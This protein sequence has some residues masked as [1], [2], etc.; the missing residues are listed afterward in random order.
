ME[1]RRELGDTQP[2]GWL[3]ALTLALLLGLASAAV[4][5]PTA[6]RGEWPRTDFSRHTVPFDEIESGGPPK[7]GIPAVDRPRFVSQKDAA[8]WLDA[9]EPVIVFEHRGEARAYPLQILMFHEIVNDTVGG[10]PV[11]VTFCPLCNA[12]IVF[13]RR[14]DGALLDFGT[15]GK[16]RKS[17]L[18]MY[19]R[20]TESWWQQFTGKGIVG[21]YADATLHQMPSTIAAFADFREAYPLGRVL[22][23]ETGYFRPYGKNP[24]RGYDRIGDQPFLFRDPVDPRLPAMERV[25]GVTRNG[26]VRIYPLTALA[27][28]P[29]VNDEVGGETVVVFSREG[30]LSALDAEVISE[31]RQIPAAAA[32]SRRLGGRV[33]T[34]EPH[35][36]R[37]VDRETRS[38]WDIF[39]RAV[40]GP[41]KGQ[42]LRPVDNGVHFAFAWLAFNPGSEVYGAAH[43]A[44]Q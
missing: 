31:S 27:T 38:V 3:R 42:R 41:L 4:S 25:L 16:L 7:D 2:A 24:Y 23:R 35:E 17:D 33:L 21:C 44:N 22:S 6:W 5:A 30:M 19:D 26:K 14:L 34:F 37:I 20:Q 36:K 29:V 15:T 13:D 11:A 32:Y 43:G 39:G 40:D 18:V 12:S 1:H 9:R 28:S 10:T 8:R